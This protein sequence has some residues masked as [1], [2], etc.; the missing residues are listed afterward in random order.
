MHYDPFLGVVALALAL[1][2]VAALWC[3]PRVRIL[4][5]IAGGALVYTLGHNSVFQGFLYGLLPELDKARSPSAAVLVFQCA[6][7]ALAAFGI[8]RLAE[9]WS[10]RFTWIL[11]TFGAFTLALA[12]FVI[13]TNKLAFPADDRVILTGVIALLA[14][15]LFAACRSGALTIPQANVLLVLLLLFEFGNGQQNAL[16]SRSD[17]NQ[18]QWLD[19]LYSNADIATATSASSPAFSAPKSPRTPSRPIGAPGTASRCTAAKAPAS[20]SI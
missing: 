11:A 13:F 10:P 19:K 15:A 9:S 7:A 2:A 17:H 6:A 5:A 14:A 18:M 20:L 16:I 8:D 4:A 3:D 1:L 12:Q